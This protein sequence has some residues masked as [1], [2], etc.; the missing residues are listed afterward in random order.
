MCNGNHSY[1]YLR[2]FSM[3]LDSQY[4]PLDTLY[5]HNKYSWSLETPR[6][7]KNGGPWCLRKDHKGHHN[8]VCLCFR[9]LSL[10]EAHCHTVRMLKQFLPTATANIR[11]LA[12]CVSH[13]GSRP[14]SPTEPLEDHSS[15]IFFFFF[16]WHMVDLQ[17]YVSLGCTT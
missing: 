2:W 15:A 3:N 11:L 12:T 4:S 6:Y 1:L 16:N 7:C 9:S 17:C 5:S 13:L 8:L 10:G 14:S